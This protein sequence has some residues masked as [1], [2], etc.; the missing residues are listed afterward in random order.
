M[1]SGTNC[2]EK[3]GYTVVLAVG[4]HSQKVEIKKAINN[5]QKN[6]RTSIKLKLDY[7]TETITSPSGL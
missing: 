7:I 4:G 2:V 5:S 6:N 3:K 1:L